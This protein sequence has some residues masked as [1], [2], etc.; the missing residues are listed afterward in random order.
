MTRPFGMHGTFYR[1]AGSVARDVDGGRP[2]YEEVL[3]P[4]LDA[5]VAQKICADLEQAVE[6][7]VSIVDLND[8]RWFNPRSVSTIAAPEDAGSRAQRQPAGPTA[9]QHAIR[10]RSTRLSHS[11][12][13][14][15]RSRLTFGVDQ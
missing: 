5:N 6:I 15:G 7:G 12:R 3:F 2:P 8:F 14:G 4:P 10:P 9:E 13:G 1:V 11:S